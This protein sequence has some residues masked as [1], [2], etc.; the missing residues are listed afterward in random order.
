[1][2]AVSWKSVPDEHDYPAAASYLS[3]LV[4][5]AELNDLIR[6]LKA[7]DI[8]Y[9]KAKDMLRASRLALLPVDNPHVASD[10]RKIKKGQS[11]SPVLLVR[12]D[13]ASTGSCRSPTATTGCAPATT[14]TRTPT[15]PA[16]SWA[17]RTRVERHDDRRTGLRTALPRSVDGR[18]VQ[19]RWGDGLMPV[20][21]RCRG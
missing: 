1:M 18:R 12:G 7:A 19:C 9:F 10:L 5:G 20:V 17:W 11:L 21:R 15:S 2:G 13:L 3:L 4:T 6:R 14:P 8:G 16:A